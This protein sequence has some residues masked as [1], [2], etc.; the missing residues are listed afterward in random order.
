MH[1][2]KR[3]NSAVCMALWWEKQVVHI[4]EVGVNKRKPAEGNLH[5]S[6]KLSR[7]YPGEDIE[8]KARGTGQGREW[9]S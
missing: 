7:I 3:C 9:N 2:R 5:E 6:R 4:Y 8:G 1:C